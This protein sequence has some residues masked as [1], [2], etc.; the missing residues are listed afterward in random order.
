L[1]VLS[2]TTYSETGGGYSG[3]A[4]HWARL[5]ARAGCRIVDAASRML[6]SLWRVSA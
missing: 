4:F 1:R 5:S 3:E 6:R 2:H